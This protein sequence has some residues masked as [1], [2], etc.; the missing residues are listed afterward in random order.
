MLIW[1]LFIYFKCTLIFHGLRSDPAIIKSSFK[2]SDELGEL[3]FFIQVQCIFTYHAVRKLL[4][5]LFL[6]KCLLFEIC[7]DGTQWNC[8]FIQ[9][10]HFL[11][12][13]WVENS[14]RLFGMPSLWLASFD[15]M[16]ILKLYLMFHLHMERSNVLHIVL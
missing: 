15:E 8:R 4:S 16:P 7:I 3:S 11:K 10:P 6:W 14:V 13:E 5:L 12:A 9:L 1:Y 2:T